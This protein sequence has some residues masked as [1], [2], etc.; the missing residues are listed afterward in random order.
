MA[1]RLTLTALGLTVVLA[2]GAGFIAYNY[3][4]SQAPTNTIVETETKEVEVPV[5]VE[6]TAEM[7]EDGMRDMGQLVTQEYYYTEVASI[8]NEYTTTFFG[9]E[10]TL[11]G[12]TT[13]VI[14]SYDGTIKAGIDFTAV[15]IEKDNNA[16]RIT[17]SLPSPII[18]SEELD[19]DSLQIYDER[20]SIFNPVSISE[21]NAS[22]A[23]MKEKA[24]E[25]AIAN[26]LMDNA[27]KNATILV[28]NFVQSGYDL[29]EYEIIVKAPEMN[30]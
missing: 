30:R 10:F 12:S 26:G 4:K 8:S 22:N 29:N 28:Q 14:Y 24:R 9:K 11:P 18:I 15:K 13:S 21:F 23:G 16:K 7:I 27:M 6:I 17:I 1:D 3:G 19:N 25:K 2:A 5:K 20:T